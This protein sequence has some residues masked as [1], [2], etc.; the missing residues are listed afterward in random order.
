[1]TAMTFLTK[2]A[3]ALVLVLAPGLALAIPLP[4]LIPS[5]SGLTD[6]SSGGG[7]RRPHGVTPSDGGTHLGSAKGGVPCK[8]GAPSPEG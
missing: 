3:L 2:I 7:P 6:A 1:M 8:P 5:V 4:P